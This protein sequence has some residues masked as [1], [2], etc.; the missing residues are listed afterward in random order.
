M[1]K[2][3]DIVVI[4]GGPAGLA[5]AQCCSSIGK[6]VVVIDKEDNIG[7]CHRV[8]RVNGLFTEHGPRIYSSAYSVFMTLL[9]EM[10]TDFFD[11]FTEYNF[12]MSRI[13]G[14][15]IWST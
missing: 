3:Y 2:I 4:G 15:T 12:S 5:L 1:N 8:R 11:L 9:E 14:E 13:G 7:G 6:K 10:N